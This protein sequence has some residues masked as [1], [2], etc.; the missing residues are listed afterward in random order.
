MSHVCFETIDPY[1]NPYFSFFLFLSFP[2]FFFLLKFISIKS[3]HCGEK[4]VLLKQLSSVMLTLVVLFDKLFL[5]K[6]EFYDLHEVC[7]TANSLVNLVFV[8]D[9][10]S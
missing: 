6:G 10:C 8:F 1:C 4:S 2:L 3:L 9:R 5:K 7:M